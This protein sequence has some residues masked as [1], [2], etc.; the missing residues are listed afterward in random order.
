MRATRWCSCSTAGLLIVM[1]A[2][3][4]SSATPMALAQEPGGGAAKPFA[5]YKEPPV[6]GT[7]QVKQ[8][9]IARDLTNVNVPFV[10]T[11]PQREQL[12]AA[13]FVVSPGVD[14]EF[15][16]LYEQGRYNYQPL[17]VTTDSLLHVYHLMFDKTLRTVEGQQFSPLLRQLTAAAIGQAQKNYM[18]LRG[19][20]SEDAAL[21][22]WAFFAVAGK[23][24]DNKTAVPAAIGKLVNGELQN[25]DAAAGVL[26]SPIFPGL[27]FGE[28][29]T[30]YVPRGHYT[31]TETLQRYFKAMMWYGRMTFRLTTKDPQVG[32]A[33]T[34]MALLVAHTVRSL[35]V[36]KLS[37]LETWN[38]L[39]APTGFFVGKSDDLTI[40][41]YL[42]VM[43]EIYGPRTDVKGLAN[44]GKLDQFIAKAE[45]L[46]APKILGLVVLFKSDVDA[47]T[48][49]LRFMG[50]RFVPDAFIFREL[51]FR[52]VGTPERRRGLPVGLDI[53]AALGSERAYALLDQM[54]ETAY[55]KYPEQMQ[56]LRATMADYSREQWTETLYNTWTYSLKTLIDATGS[57]LAAKDLA[58]YPQFMQGQDWLDRS[59]NTVL[60]SWAELKHDTLLY[61]KQVYAEMGGG[62]PK[63]P[64]PEPAEPKGYVEPNPVFFARLAALTALTREG[65][66]SRSLLSK[67]DADNL[68]KIETLAL[69]FKTMAEK[70]LRNEALT[71]KEYE[72]IRF[73]GGDLEHITIAASLDD[74]DPSAGPPLMDEQPRAAVIADVA[75]DPDH[76]FNGVP[77]PAVL[78]VGVGAVDPI[79][80]VAPIEGKLQV[81][82]GGDFSYYEFAHPAADRLTDQKWREMLDAGQAPARQSWSAGFIVTDTVS[83][84]LALAIRRF[85]NIYVGSIWD[86][87]DNGVQAVAIGDAAKKVLAEVDVL[88][89]AVQYEGR[90]QIQLDFRSFD[91]QSP[92]LAVV[93]ARET[94]DAKLYKQGPDGSEGPLLKQRGPYTID[95][96]YTLQRS[97]TDSGV[98]WLVSKM[99]WNTQP[100]QWNNAK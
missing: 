65:L 26:P 33:E 99:I 51:V 58:G 97:V 7:P 59:L 13:G 60:G 62:G 25:I 2:A 82:M 19:T 15:F 23:L 6:N 36:G 47:S 32:R 85:H 73:Y 69:S 61:A 80:V 29:Y 22:T 83:E 67:V 43:D 21:R 72:A 37:G 81:A 54:G 17:F 35:K 76:D 44:D 100:P 94:W 16:T 41:Q 71:P 31:K 98:N 93:T 28:D 38:D 52:N 57:P 88:N 68:S 70:E 8:P 63:G 30:Q 86:P 77:D 53:Y 78:E 40:P 18:A 24:L 39:Y 48:R 90:Q 27:E 56:S 66:T 12:G 5:T 50:Q 87:G 45:K 74:A 75:T 95:T 49:G 9:P 3:L 92:D 42:G 14:K 84:D 96:T 64:P 91:L 4:L 20:T 10:L 79:Y 46:P 1:V 55:A 89:A 11:K 34:R